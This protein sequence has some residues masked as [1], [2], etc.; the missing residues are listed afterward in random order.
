MLL[1]NFLDGC[2]P[3]SA[4]AEERDQY[5]EENL[6]LSWDSFSNVAAAELLAAGKPHHMCQLLRE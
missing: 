6:S 4:I 2:L 3:D 5:S 1:D